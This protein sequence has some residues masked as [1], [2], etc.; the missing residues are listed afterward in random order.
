MATPTQPLP[1]EIYAVFCEGVNEGSVKRLCASLSFATQ[2]N[3]RHVHLMFQST[4]GT[5]GDG[6]CLYN[7]IKALPIDLTI[8]NCGSV[9]SIAALAYLG[10][11]KRKTSASATFM[12]HRTTG[13]SQPATAGRL[14][15]IAESV[16]L[17]DKR[18]ETI[19]RSHV[20]LSPEEWAALDKHEL[21]F[22]AEEAIKAGLAD[23]IG[24]FGPPKGSQI[25][26]I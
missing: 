24:E 5:V 10:A 13:A 7:F 21:W 26:T 6:I 1:Q 12:L 15:S 16:V 14:H 9:V 22:S 25:Y 17:D 3:I 8:Y 19:L 23:E 18:T 2:N 20:R 11:K 4:G